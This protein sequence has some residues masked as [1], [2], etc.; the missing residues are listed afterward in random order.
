M[1]VI[2]QY[3]AALAASFGAFCMGATIGWSGPME[4]PIVN[5]EAYSF[6][7]NDDEWGW[8]S[9]ML[10]FGAACICLPIG[11]L[12]S[13]F[14]RKI[15]MLALMIPYLCGWGCIIF[16][17]EV[18]M[19][20]IG[21][22]LVGAAGGAF[23]VTGP[24]YTTEIA[25]LDLRGVMGCFFQLLLV[26]GIL[27]GFIVGGLCTP[28]VMN[29]ACGVL[30]IIFLIIFIWMPE[31]PVYLIQKGKDEQAQKSMKWLRGEGADFQ[32]ELNAMAAESK[33]EKPSVGEALGRGSTLRGLFIGIMLMLLQQ[34]TGIN[35]ILFYSTRIFEAANTGISGHLC[36]IILGVVQV[37]ATITA[38]LFIDKAGRVI[39]LL[40]SSATM[41]VTC[42]L[43]AAYFEF[44][45]NSDINWLP[46]LSIC[47]FVVGFSLGFGPVPWLIMAE[48]F[49]DDVKPICGAIV[50]TT[51]WLLAFC[52][53]KLFPISLKIFGSAVT[54]LIF[55]VISLLAVLFVL[56]IVPETKGKTL[57]EIQAELGA[58]S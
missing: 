57:T 35:A 1:G 45:M 54:F 51:S 47:V 17:F 49:A 3:I 21:R 9:S 20:F 22:F 4:Q 33:K 46:I 14:G 41:C 56:F 16:A 11:I 5:G 23:C 15:C 52:V 8:I 13:K 50:G 43:M 24:I 58:K 12:I 42:A 40:I 7:P 27:Y 36:T 10:T 28:F 48:L 53:T 30:P 25:Q 2:K 32:G 18:F 26:F 31:T 44:W 39:L 29:V 38:M 19:L 37:F 55:S 6:E 34:F